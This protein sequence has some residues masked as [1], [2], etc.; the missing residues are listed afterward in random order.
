MTVLRKELNQA[1]CHP[2]IPLSES[3]LI[4]LPK[5]GEKIDKKKEKKKKKIDVTTSSSNQVPDAAVRCD[6]SMEEQTAH[7]IFAGRD[8]DAEL[9]RRTVILECRERRPYTKTLSSLEGGQ[10]LD[11]AWLTGALG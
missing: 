3:L 1:R 11:R 7:S 2:F 8:I 10:Q 5:K 9:K 4:T 6:R